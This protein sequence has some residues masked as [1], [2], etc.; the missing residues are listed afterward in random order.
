MGILRRNFG[1]SLLL[2]GAVAI[3]SGGGA[4]HASTLF[5]SV[6]D[7]PSFLPIEG[8]KVYLVGKRPGIDSTLTDSAG[9][10][11][12]SGIPDCDMGCIVQVRTPGF[13]AYESRL[14][15]LDSNQNLQLDIQ[16]D[17]IHALTVQVVKAEEPGQPLISAQAVITASE[18]DAPRCQA[19]DSAGK[20]DFRELHSFTAY[21]LTVS[22]PGRQTTTHNLRFHGPPARGSWKV[23][24]E[25][26][27]AH[28]GKSLRGILS[29]KDGLPFPG[30]RV[31]LSCRYGGVA[32]DV[33][34]NAG[35]DGNYALAG[36]PA[37]CDS[38]VI[39]AGTDSL[40]IALPGDSTRADWEI[41]VPRTTAVRHVG[42]RAAAAIHPDRKREY[43]L[44]GRKLGARRVRSARM[45]GR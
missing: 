29:A 4:A 26:D 23:A 21:L 13:F 5:G 2:A 44:I 8:A 18:F 42:A 45:P 9:A 37:G 24:L 19:A 31:L 35:T 10:Y 39:Y 41:D 38:A 27:S 36:I 34:A 12:F 11:I 14:F 28:T 17:F 43:D 32:G 6:V 16:L 3:T 1:P 25:P 20:M 30:T 7:N 15:Q 40:A 33:F 22:A